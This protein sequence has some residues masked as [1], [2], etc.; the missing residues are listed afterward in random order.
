MLLSFLRKLVVLSSL[1]IK[2]VIEFDQIETGQ[3]R[4]TQLCKIDF[5][6]LGHQEGVS[7]LS[8]KIKELMLSLDA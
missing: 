6:R 3:I 8:L 1:L 2:G 4:E 5:E 7:V